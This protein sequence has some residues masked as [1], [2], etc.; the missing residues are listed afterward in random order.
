MNLTAPGNLCR[1]TTIQLTCGP[2]TMSPEKE[3]EMK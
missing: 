3:K 2:T 1:R